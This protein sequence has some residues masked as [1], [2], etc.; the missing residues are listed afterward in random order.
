MQSKILRA[1]RLARRASTAKRGRLFLKLRPE[2]YFADDGGLLSD[3]RCFDFVIK[4]GPTREFAD[5]WKAN[6]GIGRN[7][8]FCM[9]PGLFGGFLCSGSKFF[10]NR[11]RLP[12]VTC[13]MKMFIETGIQ[14][15]SVVFL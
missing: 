4:Y 7:I 8:Y 6:V 10:K 11:N 13:D 1:M 3:V 5:G 2:E 12:G 14:H 15:S 9:S